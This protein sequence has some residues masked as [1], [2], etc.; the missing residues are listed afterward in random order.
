MQNNTTDISKT[1]Y[2]E[3]NIARAIAMI[4]VVLGHSFPDA[5]PPLS[6]INTVCYSFHMGLFVILSGFVSARR[7][8]SRNYKIGE[9]LKSKFLRLMIPYFSFSVISLIPKLFMEKYTNNPFAL[10]DFYKIFIGINPNGG[11]W[12]LWTLFVISVIFIL[13]GKIKYNYI[14][15]LVFSAGAHILNMFVPSTFLS[16]VLK[17]AVF[18]AIG[19]IVYKYYGF[20]K[21][22]VFSIYSALAAMCVFIVLHIIG[23]SI[24]IYIFTCISASI[25]II[26]AANCISQNEKPRRLYL[27]LNEFGLY[28]YDIYLVSYFVQVPLRVVFKSM[29]PIPVNILYAAMFVLGL[30]V[31]YFASKYILRKIPVVNFLFLGNKGKVNK[32]QKN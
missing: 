30:I 21:K 28:S 3:I 32:C 12:Y 5:A 14:L 24:N 16:T 18:Y 31:P 11:L 7:L 19:I 25:F 6:M 23:Y 17:Y 20:F 4:F 22:Y 26:F 15:F 13:L 9:Q 10:K 2:K 29:F 27:V 8:L 1:Y